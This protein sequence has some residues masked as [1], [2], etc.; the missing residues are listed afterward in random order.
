MSAWAED[1]Q[2][3]DRTYLIHIALD[4][5]HEH[6]VIGEYRKEMILVLIT[7]FFFAAVLGVI[8]TRKGL[9]PLH[10]IT[11]M[12]QNVSSNRLHERIGNQ[13]WPDELMV[14]S[15]SFDDMLLRLEESFNRLRQF[16]ADLAHELRTPIHNIMGETEVALSRIRTADDYRKVLESN[17]EDYHRLMVMI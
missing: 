12:I 16:S 9:Q 5:S 6:A 14:L 2:K 17:M 7:G 4:I 1:Y 15:N 8:I 11:K 10:D 3:H 13:E